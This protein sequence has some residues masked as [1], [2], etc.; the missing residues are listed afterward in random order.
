MGGLLLLTH[1][2]RFKHFT[3]TG[4]FCKDLYPFSE[5][6][7]TTS[8]YLDRATSTWDENTGWYNGKPSYAN[9]STISAPTV[10][11][12][13]SIDITDLYNEW[14]NGTYQNYGIQLRPVSYWNNYSTFYSSDYTEDTTL[15]PKLDVIS[16]NSKPTPSPS[17]SPTPTQNSFT[18]T[19]SLMTDISRDEFYGEYDGCQTPPEKTSF[20]DTDSHAT[21]WFYYNYAQIG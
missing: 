14:Q 17:P 11:T 1:K 9:I 8:M 10:G 19:K 18:V 5:G 21:V 4:Q 3:A 7:S 16:S 12:W 15:R 6:D 13:Y 20:Y 2:I